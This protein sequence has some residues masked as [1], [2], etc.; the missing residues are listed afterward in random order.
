MLVNEAKY[1]CITQHLYGSIHKFIMFVYE[2]LYQIVVVCCNPFFRH[3]SSC[4]DHGTIF[5]IR[6]WTAKITV[7]P[8]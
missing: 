8:Y 4:M 7:D 5:Y 6:V 3:G 2:P 1:F